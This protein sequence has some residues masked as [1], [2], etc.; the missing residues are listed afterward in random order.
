M[1]KHKICSKQIAKGIIS[2]SCKT[3]DRIRYEGDAIRIANKCTKKYGKH[4]DY[5]FCP[6][7]EGFHLTTNYDDFNNP[8]AK[9][10]RSGAKKNQT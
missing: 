8:Y 5:Y 6:F 2:R 1:M 9:E 10:E 4:F 7:C 3:K